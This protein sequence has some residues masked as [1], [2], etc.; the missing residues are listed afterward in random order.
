MVILNIWKKKLKEK[1][2]IIDNLVDKIVSLE[3]RVVS[4]EDKS[5]DDCEKEVT[6]DFTE[7][8]IFNETDFCFKCDTCEFESSSKAGLNIHISRVHEKI[9]Q[10]DG[11]IELESDQ[12]EEEVKKANHKE[13]NE[14]VEELKSDNDKYNDTGD[15]EHVEEVK[16]CE[17]ISAFTSQPSDKKPRM[18]KIIGL[19]KVRYKCD[20]C[21]FWSSDRDEV[22][23][24]MVAN[25][26]T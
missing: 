26:S 23:R 10:L 20:Q 5:K 25:H 14:T 6:I 19:G 22:N 17:N 16:T 8:N 11:F 9:R 1:V 12:Y 13:V 24:H 7:E 21:Y 2:E 15:C 3:E 18:I 4:L